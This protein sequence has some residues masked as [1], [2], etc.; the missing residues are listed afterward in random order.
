MLDW[1][2]AFCEITARFLL[3]LHAWH[4]LPVRT[5]TVLQIPIGTYQ[6]SIEFYILGHILI[7]EI[8]SS[9]VTNSFLS[10]SKLRCKRHLETNSLLILYFFLILSQVAK[11]VHTPRLPD[12]NQTK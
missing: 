3:S 9:V 6:F 10:I 7:D 2:R 8:F 4:S 11:L 12:K 5:A 1:V